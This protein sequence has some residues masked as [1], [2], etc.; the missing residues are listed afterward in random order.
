MESVTNLKK[1]LQVFIS[2]TFIDLIDERQAAV[3]A[4]LDAGHIPAGMELFKAG[5]RT[6][7]ETIY[8]WIDDSDVYMLILGGR[9]GNLEEESGKSYTHLEYEY[10]IHSG[11]PVFAV[12]LSDA[13]LEAKVKILDNKNVYEIDN[14]QKYLEFKSIVMTKIIRIVNDS[15]DIML[16]IHTT[17]KDFLEDYEFVGWVRS[18]N[19]EANT[20]LLI[21][22]NDLNI[23]N[24]KLQDEQRALK[25]QLKQIQGSFTNNLAFEGQDIMLEGTY[26]V[27]RGTR[28][29][30][31]YDK[32]KIQKS[33][34]W[35]QMFL[36]W[37][38]RLLSTLNATRAK[39]ELESAL[40]D[41]MEQYFKLNEN[42]FNKIKMQYHAL[43]L[44]NIYEGGTTTGGTAE[45]I[46]ITPKGKNYL[47][48]NSAVKKI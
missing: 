17:L 26:E 34:S 48:Q 39:G 6:Q 7:L 3:Q 41:H 45:F 40:K 9:Y 15:K 12:V 10:A 21:Q 11:M 33:I 24:R 42:Q 28:P 14:K 35:D 5:N 4:V 47:I 37:S 38:P 30:Y 43:G 27:R 36:L 2:S 23:E 31:S 16:T 46:V 8:R 18:D 44:I 1:K 22:V 13:F 32:R 19:T 20:A 25:E 29:P